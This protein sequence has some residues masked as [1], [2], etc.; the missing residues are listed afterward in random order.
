M[1]VATRTNHERYPTAY[2]PDPCGESCRA[3]RQFSSLPQ[4][5]GWW[6]GLHHGEEDAGGSDDPHR[7]RQEGSAT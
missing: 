2:H 4:G 6:A 3:L 5:S 7:C 1:S